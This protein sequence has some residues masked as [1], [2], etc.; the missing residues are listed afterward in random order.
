MVIIKYKKGEDILTESFCSPIFGKITP[1]KR[2]ACRAACEYIT[3]NFMDG[4]KELDNDTLSLNNGPDGDQHDD[5]DHDDDNIVYLPHLEGV[6]KGEPSAIQYEL[7]DSD[8]DITRPHYSS[9][10]QEDVNLLSPLLDIPTED[11]K[12]QYH[13]DLTNKVVKTSEDRFHNA[14]GS[15]IFAKILKRN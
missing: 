5:K 9:L 3:R 15:P 14:E 8:E 2:N 11:R 6:P 7:F 1:V 13:A 12:R 10:N 4:L